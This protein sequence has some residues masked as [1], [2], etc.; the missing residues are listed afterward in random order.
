[1]KYN[2]KNPPLITV[3]GNFISSKKFITSNLQVIPIINSYPV[4]KHCYITYK[5]GKISQLVKAL[6]V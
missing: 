1:M 4:T 3:Y 5:P 2:N 6:F